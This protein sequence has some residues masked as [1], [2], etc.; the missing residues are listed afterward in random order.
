MAAHTIFNCQMGRG[1]TTTAMVI[2]SLLFYV[3]H[4]QLIP[5]NELIDSMTDLS[6]LS[7]S[8]PTESHY[9]AGEYKLV[10][11]LLQVLDY[12]KKAKRLLD[13]AIDA[14]EQIQNLRIAIYD[15]KLRDSQSERGRNYFLRYYFLIAFANYLL[16]MDCQA[17]EPSSSFRQGLSERREISN[18]VSV[19]S[20]ID[21]S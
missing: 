11:N 20:F 13:T 14:C 17:A 10:L 5:T 16:V 4:Q 19:K 1:R 8:T 2:A 6:V 18:M 21:F 9:L 3:R 7:I 12:G 15:F